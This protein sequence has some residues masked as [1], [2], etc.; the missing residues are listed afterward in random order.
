MTIISIIL[1]IFLLIIGGFVLRK[2]NVMKEE[3]VH[4]LNSFVY[5]IALPALIIV[6]FWDVRWAAPGLLRLVGMNCL[7][8]I[9]FA[10][11]LGVFLAL[12]PMNRRLKASVFLA[13]LVSNSI[14][15]GFPLGKLSFGPEGAD[16][17]VA[18]GT[19][20]LAF[21]IILSIIGIEIFW[22]PE[23]Y[24]GY[25]REFAKNPLIIGVVLGALTIFFGGV[26]GPLVVVHTTLAMVAAIASPAALLA[27]GGFLAGRFTREVVWFA[28]LA[29]SVKLLAFPAL[30]FVADVLVGGGI[31]EVG[32]SMLLAA[33]PVAV[34][35]FVIAERFNLDQSL[36]ASSIVM[37]TMASVV[38]IPLVLALWV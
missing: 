33:M 32:T 8:L 11:L 21:G 18:V 4:M 22:K 19:L 20:F 38:T 2:T 37:S 15:M 35:T 5:Y 34:T 6:S 30:I 36:V 13:A 29:S 14:Y 7:F 23:S 10:V 28:A 26:P 31:R 25:V 9:G 3:W 12:L 17:T 1:P 16:I 27:L 24:R